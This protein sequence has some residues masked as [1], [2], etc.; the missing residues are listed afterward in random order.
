MKAAKIPCWIGTHRG[1]KWRLAMRIASLPNERWAKKAA[2]WNPRLSNMHQ[3]NRPMGRPKKRCQDEIH[4]FLKP[5]ETEETKSNR[6][7]NN[8]TW[9]KVA[10]NRKM[11]SNGKRI[12][13]KTAAAAS[14]DSVHSR[15][16]APQDPVRPARHLNG[17]KL[18]ECEDH[19]A[20]T[21]QGPV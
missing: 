16:N 18:D 1:M 11:E 14:V 8:D 2:K 19:R 10:E 21:H 12:R 7:K 9:I 15:R 5:E 17:V 4:D 3:T 6:I 13:A 20:A